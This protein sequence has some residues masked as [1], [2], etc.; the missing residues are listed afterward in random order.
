MTN[1]EI[2]L[3]LMD[4]RR[5][6]LLKKERSLA[7]LYE[8]SAYSVAA[9]DKQVKGRGDL[10]FLPERVASDIEELF[11]SG[12]TFS[13]KKHLEE[14]IPKGLLMISG[15]PGIKPES[16]LKLYNTL[17]IDSISD[18]RKKIGVLRKRSDFGARFEEQ[19]RKSLLLYEKDYR[20]LTLFEGFSYGNSIKSLLSESGM[21]KIEVAGSVRR[22]KETV[23]N[24]NFVVSG[25]NAKEIIKKVVSYKKIEKEREEFIVLKDL[26]NVRLLFL[27]VPEKYFYSALVYYTGS[28]SHVNKLKDIA[29]AKGF[30]VSK[31]GYVLAEVSDE[32]EF[33]SM[34]GLQYIP[35]EIRE[36]EEEI[37]LAERDAIPD[38]INESDIRGDL[39]VH[40]N[41][42]DGTNSLSEIAE[43]GIYKGYD[44]VAITDH[45]GALKIANGLSEE[46]LLKETEIIDKINKEGEIT[47]LKGSEVEILKDGSLDFTNEVLKKLDLV[48]AAM[49]TGFDEDSIA[50][51]IRVEKA[52]SNENTNILAHPTGRLVSMRN[53]FSLDMGALFELAKKNSVVL[54]VNVFPKR[55]DLSASLVK[56]AI[57][58]GVKFF[59]IGTDSHNV[60][61]MNFMRYGVKILRRAWL[62]PEN[63]I[64]TFDTQELKGFLCEKRH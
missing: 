60:G 14:E 64:N 9:M 57:R 11:F 61:H 6:L 50:N 37:D 52:L 7:S 16:A 21:E 24:I 26:R 59:S 35:P 5:M 58:A 55:M 25:K 33:Y 48:L 34:I 49:H 63:V 8:K 22:G 23:N 38:L 3:N 56:Q 54:E 10:L 40:S 12:G 28:R 62:T 18:L 27:I 31:N 20:E 39:H 51:N 30:S 53:G 47:I 44:Y 19:V 17:G 36:G 29:K 1:W 46:R 13:F 43:E 41:F 32:E 45:S 42:S 15:L 4:V 2:Y